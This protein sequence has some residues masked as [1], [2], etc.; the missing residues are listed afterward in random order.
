MFVC[1]GCQSCAEYQRD[2]CDKSRE[3]KMDLQEKKSEK[4]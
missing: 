1:F 3:N 2:Y 4:S